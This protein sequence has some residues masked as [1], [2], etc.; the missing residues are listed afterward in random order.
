M[1]IALSPV[2]WSNL[3]E[4]LAPLEPFKEASLALEAQSTPTIHLVMNI[5]KSLIYDD[6]RLH[7]PSY[8]TDHL[9]Y[10]ISNAAVNYITDKVDNP[11]YL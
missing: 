2:D 3:A 4:I 9:A 10:Y 5:L 11:T 1:Q 6:D 7:N 8:N